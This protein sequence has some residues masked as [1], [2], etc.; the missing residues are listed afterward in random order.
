MTQRRAPQADNKTAVRQA[1]QRIWDDLD[2]IEAIAGLLTQVNSNASA[3]TIRQPVYNDGNDT[4]D[5]ARANAA[6]TV[7][8]LGLVH[9]ASIG[10]SVA[11][12][13]I[14]NGTLIA[15]IA[16]WD[17][18]TGDSG[19]LTAGTVY[20]LDPDTAGMLTTTGPSAAS[21]YVVRVG[22]AVSTTRME[23]SITQPILL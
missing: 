21:K 22:R 18:V 17:V 3:I 19:G 23:I 5:L 15:T 7:E 12:E 16:Q 4:V 10:A 14:S 20:Y 1:F 9:T 11:G 6:G 8:V 2:S 13:F